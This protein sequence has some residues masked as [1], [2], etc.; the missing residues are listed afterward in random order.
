M[1]ILGYLIPK[2]KLDAKTE[3]E[4]GQLF[5][6]KSMI[7]IFTEISKYFDRTRRQICFFIYVNKMSVF[8]REEEGNYAHGQADAFEEVS[9]YFKPTKR[10]NLGE[11][12]A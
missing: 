9:D 11:E 4:R 8:K 1:D 5:A 3:Y 6:Y 12:D 10:K 7:N 2:S